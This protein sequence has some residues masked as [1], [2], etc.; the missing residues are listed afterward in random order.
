MVEQAPQDPFGPTIPTE[1][2]V[3]MDAVNLDWL[4]ENMYQVFTIVML[5]RAKLD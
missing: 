3:N 4:V 2:S 5:N 1:D